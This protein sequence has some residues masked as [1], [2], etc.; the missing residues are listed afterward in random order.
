MSQVPLIPSLG[1]ID[2]DDAMSAI[3]I[4]VQYLNN[5]DSG[6][7][8]WSRMV[9]QGAL[10]V[11]INPISANYFISD[12]DQVVLVD[13]TAGVITVTL[14]SAAT[15]PGRRY[16][17]KDWKGTSATH[18]ITIAT[19]ASQLIDGSSTQTLTTNYQAIEVV[20]DNINWSIIS[21]K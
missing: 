19:S 3:N 6:V 20:S 16:T 21:N 1:S 7:Q 14:P 11:R 13:S 18:T 17:I 15:I 8:P 5:Q 12:L 10:T 4:I 2:D 9:I